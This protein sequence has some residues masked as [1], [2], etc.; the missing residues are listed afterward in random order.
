MATLSFL[1]PVFNERLRVKEA[2]EEML[3]AELPVES[4]ELIVVD[5]GSTDGTRELLQASSWPSNLRL[6]F[7]DT[8]RGKG[9]ALQTALRHATGDYAAVMDADLEYT[10]NEY[11]RLLGPL[12]DGRADAVFGVRGFESHAAYNFW[13][14]MGNKCMTLAANV[15]YNSWLADIMTCQKVM[16][17]ELFRSLPLAES[18]FGIEPEITA[19]L[20]RRGAH[21]YEVPIAYN[22]RSREEG[23]KLKSLDA[24]RVL[25]TLLRCRFS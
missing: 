19:R 20:L 22:S 3:T 25:R 15:L 2:L 5:D 9:T 11:A 21:I 24:V 12:M 10:T 16:S 6:V 4:R 8:N 14:V 13:Y 1:V 17:T 18:G 7:H 23:K